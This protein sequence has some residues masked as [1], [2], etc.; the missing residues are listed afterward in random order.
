[1]KYTNEDIEF[2]IRLLNHREEFPKEEVQQ[3][4]DDPGHRALVDELAAIR[5]LLAAREVGAWPTTSA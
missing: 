5:R 4:L 1:M 3:W 2:A